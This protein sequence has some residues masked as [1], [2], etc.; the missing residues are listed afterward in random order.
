MSRPLA[1]PGSFARRFASLCNFL[2]AAALLCSAPSHARAADWAQ[3]RGP[4]AS[5]IAA[6]SGPLPTEF[7]FE[8]NVRWSVPLGDGIASP[9]VVGDRVFV[10]AMSGPETFA[11]YGIDAANGK[12]LWQQEIPTGKLPAIT[13]PNSHASSTPASDGERV[14]VYFSTVGLLAFDA[15]D[16]H[17]AW[18]HTLPL[19]AYLM[20]WGAA[21]SPIVYQDLVIFDQ[22]D[23]LSPYLLAL[24]AKTGAER[25]KTPR[26]EMLAGYSV[27]VLCEAGGRT[28]L[29]VAGT[30][31]LKGYDPRT[32]KEL[33]TCNTLLRTIMTTPVVRD[34]VIY[35]SVQSYGD[36][37]RV[38]KF[39]LLEWK[40]TNQDGKLTKAELPP[41]FWERFDKADAN[42][43]DFLE[44]EELDTAFQSPSNMSGGGSIVQAIQGG[45]SGDVTKTHVLWNLQKSKAPSNVC[46]P[47]LTNGRL[48]LLKRG[49]LSSCF[50]SRT[51]ETI[52]QTKRIKNLGEYYASPVAADGKIFVIN[53]EGIMVVLADEPDVKVLAKNDMG[54]N[55]LATPAIAHGAIFIRTRE[56]LFC[57]GEGK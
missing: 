6:E 24:D 22:D 34:G 10:T 1:L 15:A 21:A 28:D 30:G 3:F 38:L 9:I 36:T 37:D 18:R 23:D 41:E 45:G 25:W 42:Q 53:D 8:H 46:S 57:V 49:G 32:G 26:P 29:V 19:P 17:E 14:Y 35:I 5:G 7:S 13:Q 48:F 56:K 12:I 43:D 20:D 54:A 39:A 2:G 51:G 16:G 52:W 47:L 27:P 11:V 50:D 31:K 33:W 4:N 44:G 40:D 55:C